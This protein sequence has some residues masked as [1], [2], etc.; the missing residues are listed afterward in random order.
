MLKIRC[1]SADVS[2]VCFLIFLKSTAGQKYKKNI[3]CAEN[4]LTSRQQIS[5]FITILTTAAY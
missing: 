4:K 3:Y 1:V 5:Y 2:V